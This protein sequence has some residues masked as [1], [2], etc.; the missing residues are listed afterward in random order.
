MS[1]E[2]N[3]KFTGNY[4]KKQI[5]KV[6]TSFEKYQKMVGEYKTYL[7]DKVHPNNRTASYEKNLIST[8]NRLLVAADELDGENPGSGVFG[9][10]TLALRANLALK[11][12]L[13]DYEI[14][15]RELELRIKKLEKR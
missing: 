9:L 11:D 1:E 4:K 15:N 12:K 2:E 6:E 14:K 8:L 10:I 7:E 5:Q 13:L 3:L